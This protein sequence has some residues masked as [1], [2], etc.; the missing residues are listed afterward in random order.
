MK[1]K[2]ALFTEG[3][4]VILIIKRIEAGGRLWAQK[5]LFYQSWLF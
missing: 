3:V 4:F 1:S 2:N 5:K